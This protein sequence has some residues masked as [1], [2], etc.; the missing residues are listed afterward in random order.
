MST[1]PTT[2]RPGPKPW[3]VAVV[4]GMASYL[5]AA[6]IVSSGNALVMYQKPLGLTGDQIGVL[7]FSLTLGIAVGAAVGGRLGDRFGRKP[8]FSVTM[9][10]IVLAMACNVFA[11]GFSLLLVGAILAGLCTGADLPVSIATIAEAGDDSNRGKMVSFSQV[12]WMMGIIVPLTLTAVIGDMGRVGGQIIFGS[13][14]VVALIVLLARMVLPESSVWLAARDE[15]VHHVHTERAEHV[16]IRDLLKAPY[17]IPFI[18]LIIFYPLVNLAANTGGQ[19]GTYLWVNNAGASVEFAA[20]VGLVGVG[21]GFVLSLVFL[22]IVDT[23]FRMLAF[24]I[25][26]A[27]YVLSTVVPVVFGVSIATLLT[28]QFLAAIGGA[29]AFEAILKVW[30]QESFPTLLRSTA[31][32]TII[33]VARVC[34]AL[35]ALV[36]PRLAAAGPRGLFLVLTVLIAIGMGAAIFA[37]RKGTRNEFD[38]E[39]EIVEEGGYAARSLH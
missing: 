30:T 15:R 31:Q 22:R 6:T 2:A 14:G 19:F 38:L 26:A 36:T 34:A 8:V 28:W 10:G 1:L 4:A 12:L 17:A 5:D 9:I 29:F 24:Y 33:A 16:R 20:R 11:G 7:A 25:G 21:V 27:C 13:V 32:G 3:F 23:R 35:L 37:F 39:D 18:C